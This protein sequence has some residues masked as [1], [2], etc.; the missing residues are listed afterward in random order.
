MATQ[1]TYT[2]DKRDVNFVLWEFLKADVELAKLPKFAD[3]DRSIYDQTINEAAKLAINEIAPINKVCDQ[4]GAKFDGGKVTLPKEVHAVY[5]KY[6]EGGWT[7]LGGNPDFGGQGM[8]YTVGLATAEFFMG[9]NVAFTMYPGLTGAAARVVAHYGTDDMK[10][11]YLAKL[12]TGEW[13]GTMC[14]TEPGAGTD[15]GNAKTTAKPNGDTYLIAGN[16]IFISAG[17][18]D[19]CDNFVHL[20]LARIDGAPKGTAGIS[21]FIVPKFFV[22]DDGSL[23]ARNDMGCVGIEHKMGIKGSSTCSRS[24]RKASAWAGSSARPT[25]A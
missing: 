13:Q 25:R 6:C 15:V 24:A 22:N 8:P 18:H 21:L 7:G 3:F 16:K 12:Y 10:N 11:K 23:G 20:V 9:A 17:E 4:V 1:S 2:V 5:K 14:L 19:M